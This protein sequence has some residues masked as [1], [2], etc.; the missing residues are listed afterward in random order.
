MED[1]GQDSGSIDLDAI[2]ILI[3]DVDK[4][5]ETSV[6]PQVTPETRHEFAHTHAA[7]PH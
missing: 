4:N 5:N 3:L 2:A 7:S 1:D 6:T